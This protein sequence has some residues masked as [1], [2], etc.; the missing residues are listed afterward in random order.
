V[1]QG[2]LVTIVVTDVVGPTAVHARLGD[3]AADVI[4]SA[5]PTAS[6]RVADV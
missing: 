2:G 6:A 1:A 4:V 3:H 5:H